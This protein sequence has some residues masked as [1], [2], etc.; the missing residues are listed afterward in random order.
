MVSGLMPIDK[1]AALEGLKSLRQARPAYKPVVNAGSVTS[2]GDRALRADVARTRFGLS[3]KGVKVGI[4]S[5]SYNL[6]GGAAAGVA[7]GDLP[8]NVQ[9]LKCFLGQRR[10]RRA[11]R[12]GPVHRFRRHDSL[13]LLGGQHRRRPV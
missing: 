7:S 5:T 4:L 2:Q 1:L 13:C 8:A 3:G 6:Q 10:E 12:Y 9:M 11:D